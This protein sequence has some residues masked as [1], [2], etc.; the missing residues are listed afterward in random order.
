MYLFHISEYLHEELRGK[1]PVS[2]STEFYMKNMGSVY[3]GLWVI[4][5]F[6]WPRTANAFDES[7]VYYPKLRGHHM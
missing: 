6:Q 2:V 3:Y 4:C 7:S 1:Y 5:I